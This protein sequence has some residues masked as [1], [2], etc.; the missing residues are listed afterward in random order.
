MGRQERRPATPKG[1]PRPTGS[2]TPRSSSRPKQQRPQRRGRRGHG[3]QDGPAGLPSRAGLHGAGRVLTD[4]TLSLE[5]SQGA[6]LNSASARHRLK[7]QSRPG[8]PGEAGNHR[9]NPRTAAGSPWPPS[10]APPDPPAGDGGEFVGTPCPRLGA[11]RPKP[12]SR[13]TPLS[14]GYKGPP[15]PLLAST[16]C[17]NS[18]LPWFVMASLQSASIIR[19]ILPHLSLWVQI[20][21][22]PKDTSHWTRALLIQ[23]GLISHFNSIPSAKYLV[24]I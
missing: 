7:P 10:R 16:G 24:S 22:F 5:R 4:L 6:A 8:G 11:R 19:A 3:A 23:N 21:L 15:L 20:S 18:L 14:Q 9:R 13:L 2:R 12:R 17:R 1:G